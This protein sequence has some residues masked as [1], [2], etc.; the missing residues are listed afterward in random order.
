MSDT[1][2]IVDTLSLVFQVYHA[3]RQPMTGS[4]GQPTN[5]LFGFTGDLEHLIKE[6]KPTHLICAMDSKGEG[7]RNK[8]YAEYKAHREAPP[9]D[10]QVQ[11]PLVLDLIRAY[12]IPVVIVP[13]WEADDVI[14]TLATRAA[15]NGMDVRLVTNDKDARQLL[16]DKIK[17]YSIRKK[18]MYDIEDL[19][20]EW[21]IRP[22]QVVDFQSLMGDS[23]DGVPGVPQVGPKTAT[24]LIQEFGTLENVLAN[25]DKVKGKKVSQNLK[26]FA[27]LAH[28][29]R[30][31]VRLHRELPIELDWDTARVH[32]PDW[33][34]LVELFTDY[35]FRRYTA[36]AQSQLAKSSTQ[37]AAEI[38]TRDWK[39]VHTEEEFEKFLAA[40]KQQSKFCIDLETT[41]LNAM[42]AEIVGWAFCWQAGVGYYIP[43]DGPSGSKTLNRS[44]VLVALKPIIE[45][46]ARTAINQNIKYDMLV[47]K[48]HGVQIANVGLDPMI[49][50]YLL[51]AGERSHGIDALT[52]KYLDR[53][54]IP[55]S[56]LIGKGTR[57]LKMFE[58]DV[59][60]V[61]EYASEDADFAWQLADRIEPL[62]KEQSLWDLYWNLERPLISILAQ[63]EMNGIRVNRE[64]LKRQSELV[65]KRLVGL[66]TECHELAGH[67]F[68]LNSPKQLATILF[69]ELHL[70]VIKRT[71]TG[72]ST[73]E[74]VLEE[75][76]HKHPL[77]AKL[78][79]HR[80]LAKLKGTYID[81]LPQMINRKT[82]NVHTSF[83]Q[84]TAATG[85]L[86]STDPNLQ[87]IP[88]RT[89]EGRLI[90]RAFEPSAPGWKLV[91]LDYSQI[92][93]RMLAHFC[94]DPVMLEAFR[95][96]ED[97][98]RRVASEVYGV[99][100]DQVTSDQR[101]VAK[102]VNFGVIYGQ[103]SFGLANA[104]GIERSVAET[105]ITEYFQRYA[106]VEKFMHRTLEEVAHTGFA[107]T[108]LGRRQAIDG[109][110]P[111]R[112]RTLNMPERTAVNTVIQGSAADLVKQAMIHVDRAMR[113]A[114]RPAR[115][116]L[117][118]H[119]ELVFE[120]PEAEVA[121][122]VELAKREMENALPLNV[123]VVVDVKVGDN[124]L[125]AE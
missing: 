28:T 100:A 112:F 91:C 105:F 42:E 52:K 35:G 122:L 3:I 41:S 11:I 83:S 124:W 78:M 114:Q 23:V 26:E 29:S 88:V 89:E 45:D 93:L 39:I 5:A 82:G 79:E 37:A 6:K 70:P 20:K 69:D 99:P 59:D 60:K 40:L 68:N 74:E 120:A 4:R 16:S 36:E 19:E 76:S 38:P 77:P 117:Q 46:P 27:H 113:K 84:V 1:L 116:L 64:E 108:I 57:Q 81:A 47:L 14:A 9:E 43:V 121:S 71:K 95:Q 49:G 33:P 110:R 55:T 10:L 17:I 24:A 102:A 30:E 62:L 50:D 98:H 2:Y 63:L 58:V 32:E 86:A 111:K 21:G 85:R 7:E 22:D 61:A 123:P 115:M 119:D 96:G 15:A 31:L 54:K 118:I 8:I 125:D 104:L 66:T 13:G 90:R 53:E 56:D 72:P 97:I 65:E 25:A 92:E 80:M 87:N 44:K 12:N 48:N 51:D 34:K 75:L 107:K 103:T 106:E 67:E 73:D 18:R 109:I 101:R 94:Q